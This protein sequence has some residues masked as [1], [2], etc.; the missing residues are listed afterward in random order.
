MC[1]TIVLV[2]VS[3]AV[4]AAVPVSDATQECLD[5]HASIHPG[6]VEG[7][8]KSRH[9]NRSPEQGKAVDELARRVSA[10]TIPKELQTVAVGCAECHTLRPD[11]HKD[12]VE[13]NGYTIH[14]V[15]SPD[16]CATCHPVE[17]DQYSGN[18]MAWA[19]K[20]LA[21]NPLYQKLQHAIL[22]T[23]ALEN[24]TIALKAANR[25]T[26]AEA[27]YHCHGTKL[28][29]DGFETRDTD[30]GEM[31]FAKII[32]WPNQ[33]SGRVNLDGSQGACSA[34]H[35]RH[36]F[37]I[38]MA[39][40][41]YTCK[42]CHTG[43]DV[44]A[45][46]V[47]AASKHGNIFSA[48]HGDWDFHAVPWTIGKDFSA[49]TCATCHISLLVDTDETVI[50]ER[51]HRINDRLASRIFGLIYAHPQPKSPDTSLIRNKDGISLPTDFDGG[52]ASPY[53]IDKTEQGKRT[54]A[55]QAVCLTCHDASWVKGH[56]NRYENTIDTTNRAT[57]TATRI[58]KDIWKRGLARGIVKGGNPFDEAVERK[59]SDIWL[60]YANTIRFASAMAGGGDYGVFANGRYQ[61]T[62]EVAELKDW[63]DLRKES[64]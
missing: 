12:A 18:L 55:M 25:E 52:L 64:R 16:D 13:H 38:E 32:G 62:K 14:V 57:L 48:L 15:V 34:C 28:E 43:P 3:N 61:L 39:R 21:E 56:W 63:M 4:F 60:F 24:D 26:K 54:E 27:C 36:T 33:G 47:Y 9:A 29:F 58:M 45:F 6:I 44:P 2:F 51:T 10:K 41:P 59:W 46:K 1:A 11:A 5:C 23:P 35:T 42:A 50:V 37:S 19:R 17:A 30:V 49:P 8:Q 7:W 53:L 22:G 20:N 40:K 31:E